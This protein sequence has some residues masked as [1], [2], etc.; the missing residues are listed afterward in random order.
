VTNLNQILARPFPHPFLL[1]TDKLT[2]VQK[3]H[4][5]GFGKT[6]SKTLSFLKYRFKYLKMRFLSILA[7]PQEYLLGIELAWRLVEVVDGSP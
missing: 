4:F 1:L 2:K 3:P 5:W 7:A 6:P